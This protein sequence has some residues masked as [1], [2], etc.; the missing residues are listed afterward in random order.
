MRGDS[1][2]LVAH[3]ARVRNEPRVPSGGI[4]LVSAME[5]SEGAVGSNLHCPDKG[6]HMAEEVVDAHYGLFALRRGVV[7]SR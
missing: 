6:V 7:F 2:F 4:H 1:T 5:M 3:L